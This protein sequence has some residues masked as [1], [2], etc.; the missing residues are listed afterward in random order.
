MGPGSNNVIRF[1]AFEVDLAARQLRKGG[2]RVRLE[3]LPFRVL[4][5]LLAR[6]GQVVERE[7]LTAE[8]QAELDHLTRLDQVLYQHAAQRCPDAYGVRES[9]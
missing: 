9:A 7:E 1:G 2:V 8:I 3:G 5:M 4:A 6:S